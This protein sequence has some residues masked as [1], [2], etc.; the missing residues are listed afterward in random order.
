MRRRRVDAVTMERE[1]LKQKLVH[2]QDVVAA[3]AEFEQWLAEAMRSVA[4]LR[5]KAPR[6]TSKGRTRD[7]AGYVSDEICRYRGISARCPR[8]A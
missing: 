8:S 2:V 4:T 5:A 1:A 7:A 3:R 6:R